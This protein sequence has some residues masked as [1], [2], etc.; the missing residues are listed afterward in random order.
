MLDNFYRDLE[1]GKKAEAIVLSAF[2]NAT[3]DYKFEDVSNQRSFFYKGDIKAVAADGREIFIEVKNDSRIAETHNI[4]CEEEVYY[5]NADYYGSGNMESDSD[6]YV[7]VSQA[8]KKIYV[9]DFKILKSIYKKG[10]YKEITHPQQITFC[11][12]L[13][14]SIVRKNGG[15]IATLDYEAAAEVA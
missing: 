6:I 8:E 7:V 13:P 9:I 4:L 1:K 10:E 12:L 2:S 5:K 14:L 3:K 15:L 11:Y